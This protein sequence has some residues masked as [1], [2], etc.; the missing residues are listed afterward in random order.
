MTLF[1]VKSLS[2]DDRKKVE[3]EHNSIVDA[4]KQNYT[5]LASE[6][7]KV[8]KLLQDQTLKI[9]QDLNSSENEKVSKAGTI[10]DLKKLLSESNKNQKNLE[11]RVINDEKVRV[12]AGNLHTIGAFVD[13]FI[14]GN[15]VDDQLVRGAIKR[16]ISSNLVVRDGNILE[17]NNSDELTGRTGDQVLFD[18][19]SND[20]FSKYLIASHGIGGG[21]SG[22]SSENVAL[23]TMTRDEYENS[24]L[25][26][27]AQFLRDGGNII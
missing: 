2:D 26:T 1:K 6:K 17:I 11:E 5:K 27:S 23:K 13:E 9:Q 3:E 8:D 22:G 7:S 18:A 19:K 20:A 15:V 24:P 25:E 12:E 21:A 4:L 10:D 16:D 14:N